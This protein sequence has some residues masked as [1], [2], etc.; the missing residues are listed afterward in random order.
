MSVTIPDLVRLLHAYEMLQKRL[1][2]AN[3]RA[4]NIPAIFLA[5]NTETL[6]KRPACKVSHLRRFWSAKSPD[7]AGPQTP[8]A[9]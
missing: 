1:L 8:A 7:F 3:Q 9:A 6:D 2:K 4:R 5:A